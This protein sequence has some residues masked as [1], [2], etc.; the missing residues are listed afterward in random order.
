MAP[1]ALKLLSSAVI[2]AVCSK[3]QGGWEGRVP[4]F[5][6]MAAAGMSQDSDTTVVQCPAQGHG[7][8]V[9]NRHQL[10]GAATLVPGKK[11]NLV[12]SN[13]NQGQY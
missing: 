10:L 5:N 1:H 13:Q 6:R 9:H 4:S 2:R 8:K 12:T 11:K 3:T 7:A